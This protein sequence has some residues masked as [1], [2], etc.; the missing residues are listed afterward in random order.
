MRNK[1]FLFVLFFFFSLTSCEIINPGEDVPSYIRVEN[2]SLVTD[3]LTQGSASNKITDAWLYVDNQ[4]LGAYEMPVTIPVLEEGIHTIAIR[5]GVIVNGIS[6]TRV[7]YPFYGF[8]NDTV[9]LARGA[10]TTISPV[11]NYFSGAVFALNESFSGPGYDV[12]ASSASDTNYTV[13]NDP[14]NSFEGGTGAAYLDAAHLIFEC[15][16]DDSLL[17]PVNDPVYMELNYKSNT[18]FSVSMRAI[19]SQQVYDIFIL[20][21]RSTAEWKKIYINLANGILYYPNALGFKPYIHME[22]NS[23]VGDARLYFDNIKVVHF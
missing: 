19:T 1:I 3:S 12:V 13:I 14:N 8:Y 16:P 10:V 15:E 6:A 7:Y 4:L 17:L 11:V 2:I 9:N 23:A 22:R 5:G 18:D 21:I 20:N